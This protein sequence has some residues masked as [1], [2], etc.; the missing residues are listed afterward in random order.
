MESLKQFEKQIFSSNSVVGGAESQLQ[1]HIHREE[2]ELKSMS[3][4]W[5]WG[6]RLS[7]CR[8]PSDH[9]LFQWEG[10]AEPAEEPPHPPLVFLTPVSSLHSVPSWFGAWLPPPPTGRCRSITASSGRFS[11]RT[12]T[13]SMTPWRTWRTRLQTLPTRSGMKVRTSCSSRKTGSHLSS[14]NTH[15]S[16]VRTG[17]SMEALP[18]ALTCCLK[19]IPPWFLVSFDCQVSY[20]VS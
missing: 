19:V 15:S 9:L 18:A 2:M 8:R 11:W 20:S 3:E 13:G 7:A 1:L 16:G 10:C 4:K 14:S 12:R 17:V 6:M 5:R